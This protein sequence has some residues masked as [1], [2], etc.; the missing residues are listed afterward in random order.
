M[1]QVQILVIIDT[2][3]FCHM[4]QFADY[5]EESQIVSLL[6]DDDFILF[7]VVVTLWLVTSYLMLH[8]TTILR[9]CPNP[10]NLSNYNHK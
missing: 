2:A 8:V 6:D 10:Q 3:I 5:A 1:N 4:S 9:Y 7:S